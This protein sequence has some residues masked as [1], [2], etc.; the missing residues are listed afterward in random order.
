MTVYVVV[1]RHNGKVETYAKKEDAE[2]A[3]KTMNDGLYMSGANNGW[4]YMVETEVK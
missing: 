2:K 3:V 1:Y 4:A